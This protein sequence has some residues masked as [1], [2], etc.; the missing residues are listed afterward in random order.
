[1]NCDCLSVFIFLLHYKWCSGFGI[2]LL[3]KVLRHRIVI[4]MY[5]CFLQVHVC[6]IIRKNQQ[7]SHHVYIKRVQ[8]GHITTSPYIEGDSHSYSLPVKR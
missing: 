1:M 6:I 8:K 3:V 5:I 2:D 4:I 7:H